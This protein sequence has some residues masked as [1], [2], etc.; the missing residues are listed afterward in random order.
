MRI[1]LVEDDPPL[2]DGLSIG[3]RQAGHAVD[4]VRDGEAA[5]LRDNEDVKE[6]YLGV[7]GENRKSFRDVKHYK[8]R[9][10]WLG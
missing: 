4:W 10:R 1:L 9:K 3:L 8:R 5:S 7:A 6:F 2:G